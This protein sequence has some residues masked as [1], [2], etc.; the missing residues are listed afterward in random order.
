MC[1]FRCSY[2]VYKPYLISTVVDQKTPQGTEEVYKPYLISTV[3]DII[4]AFLAGDVYKPYLIST[5]VDF[6]IVLQ[7]ILFI[8]LI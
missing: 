3:V 6:R 7:I 5:V 4:S 1:Y 2:T 8:N